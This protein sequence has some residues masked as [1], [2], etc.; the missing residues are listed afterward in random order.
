VAKTATETDG[1]PLLRVGELARAVGKTV[2]AIHLYEELGLLTP[3]QRTQGGFRLYHQDAVGR[4]N[5]IM[6][7]QAIGFS[8]TEI[9][10]FVSEFERAGI[11]R[12]AATRVRAVFQDKLAAIRQQLAQL[13]VVEN[14]LVEALEY[15][16]SC[17]G[18]A[19]IYTP[20]ECRSCD[21]EGHAVGV[22]PELFAG[23]SHAHHPSPGAADASVVQLRPRPAPGV[24][25]REE[26]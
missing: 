20:G 12:D 21:H 16:E 15:L 18:C 3:A 8:L 22:A 25:D 17:Q 23:L 13:R 19:P 1:R 4:I 7:L 2:R 14:D 9:E 10:G 26:P 5:W 6:K 11:G 24:G